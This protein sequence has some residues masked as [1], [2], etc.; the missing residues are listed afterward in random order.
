V[1]KPQVPEIMRQLDERGILQSVASKNDHDAA[2]GKLRELG[3][4]EYF[5][6]PQINW[7][8]KGQLVEQIRAS[9][10]SAWTRCLRGRPAVRARGGGPHP[11]AG[12]RIDTAELDGCWTAGDEPRVHH[13]RLQIRAACTWRTCS[14]T[15][16]RRTSWGPRR[17][18]GD[19]GDALRHRP[20]R[21]GRP[22]ARRGAD[23]AHQ[24]AQ[25]HRLHLLLRRAERLA[26]SPDHLLLVASLEDRYGTYGKIGLALVEKTPECWTLKLLLMSC[27][28][29]SRGVG[30][31]MMNYIMEQPARPG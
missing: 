19:A 12:A 4:D 23:G 5:L 28:V 9:S 10:T 24:P 6:Y 15:A 16:P 3:L 20:L 18:P 30:T 13:G 17:V 14:G 2:M 11:P 22:A 1:L 8:S 7:N 27:R 21:R 31:I 26:Q 29:M 25:H